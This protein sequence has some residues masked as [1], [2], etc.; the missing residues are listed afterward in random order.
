MTDYD[1]FQKAID[2]YGVES[3]LGMLYEEI[4]ELMQAI[5]KYHRGT[6]TKEHV[7]E[8]LAD[9]MIMLYQA[10]MIFGVQSEMVRFREQK[11]KRLSERLSN[12]E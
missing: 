8:E 1:I 4:G 7:A 2:T 10:S 3:Q 9:C 6:G 5:N 12:L 11:I